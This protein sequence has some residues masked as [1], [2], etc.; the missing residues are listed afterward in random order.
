ME[1]QSLIF[2]AIQKTGVLLN[3]DELKHIQIEHLKYNKNECLTKMGEVENYYYF[4]KSGSIKV[5]YIKED[6]EFILDFWFENEIIF[7]FS[8][9]I[10]RLPSEIEL[11]AISETV[12]E[13]IHYKQLNELYKTSHAVSEIGRKLTEQIYLHKVKKQIS[14]LTT[15]A[16]ERYESLVKKSGRL[17]L[18][19]SVKDIAS[20]LGIKSESLSRIRRKYKSV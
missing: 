8:S 15:T 1:N 11:R 18:E 12:A 4:I 2:A 10:E 13:R 17:I 5:S 20:Y 7:S 9:L 6:K 19:M 14:L 16:E 3:P